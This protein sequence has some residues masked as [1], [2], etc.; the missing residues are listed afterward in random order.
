MVPYLHEDSENDALIGNQSTF[1][2]LLEETIRR[3]AANQKKDK[4]QSR[5]LVVDVPNDLSYKRTVIKMMANT[6]K[7]AQQEKGNHADW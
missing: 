4:P 2:Y 1:T 5:L 3:K 7:Y 6:H